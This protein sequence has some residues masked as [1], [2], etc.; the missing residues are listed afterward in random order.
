MVK[1]W[2]GY[3][4]SLLS[5]KVQVLSDNKWFQYH[6][7]GQNLAGGGREHLALVLGKK[8]SSNIMLVKT[9]RQYFPPRPTLVVKT[10]PEYFSAPEYQRLAPI[11]S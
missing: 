9:W 11:S 2:L 7:G 4:S 1:T 6:P 3:I 5:I 8:C 10:W